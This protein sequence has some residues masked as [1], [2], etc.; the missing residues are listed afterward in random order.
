MSCSNTI[1]AESVEQSTVMASV[2]ISHASCSN[3]VLN[4]ENVKQQ[5]MNSVSVE[6]STVMPHLFPVNNSSSPDDPDSDMLQYPNVVMKK[7]KVTKRSSLSLPQKKP[8]KLRFDARQKEV[9]VNS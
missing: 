2:S 4:S 1:T 7:Y 9:S 8:M 3:P 5:D 6:E